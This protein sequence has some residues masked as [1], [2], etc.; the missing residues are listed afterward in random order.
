MQAGWGRKSPSYHSPRPLLLSSRQG[1]KSVPEGAGFTGFMETLFSF[2]TSKADL[3]N[4]IPVL[5]ACSLLAMLL[6]QAICGLIFVRLFYRPTSP[7]AAA[8]QLPIVS[9]LLSLRGADPQLAQGLQGLLTQD[10]PHYDLRVVVDS[11]EDPAWQIVQAALDKT[12]RL[13]VAELRQKRSSCSLKCSGLVQ[14][15]EDLPQQTE[16]VVL[17][18]ADLLPHPNWLRELVAPL[19]DPHIGA[20]HGNRWYWPSATNW[21]SLVRYLWNAAAVVPMYFQGMPWG[22][23]LALRTRVLR[24]ARLLEKW[25]QTMVE[26]ALLR[27]ALAAEGLKVHFVPELMMVNREWCGLPGS[28]DF[29]QRQLTWTKLYHAGWPAVVVHAVVSSLLVLGGLLMAGWS[30]LTGQLQALAWSGGSLVAYWMGMLGLLGILEAGV[31]HVV[32]QREE[33]VFYFGLWQQCKLLLAL[34]LTQCIHLRATLGAT[35]SRR[36][37][38]RG[39]RYEVRG[40]QDIKMVAYHPFPAAATNTETSIESLA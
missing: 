6:Y 7:Q 25:S 11:H 14:L 16:V 21:G 32:R 30:G 28:R 38:W 29:I 26:D 36:V 35:W 18:D 3:V 1:L 2:T 33:P 27:D 39:I 17:A 31:R 24:E 34:P 13:Q 20:T 10:Y 4:V 8:A 37:V 5:L 23:S 12:T 40:P 9:V 22:G 19:A 15:V